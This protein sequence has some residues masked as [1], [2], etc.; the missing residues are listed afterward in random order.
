MASPLMYSTICPTKLD[1]VGHM[2]KWIGKW[3]VTDHYF[4][5]GIGWTGLR[6][7]FLMNN[8]TAISTQS[9]SGFL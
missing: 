2:P 3:P 8:E 1:L 7:R 5:L 4:E 6:I 9:K